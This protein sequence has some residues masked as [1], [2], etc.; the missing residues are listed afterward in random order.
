MEIENDFSK[1][2]I[3]KNIMNMAV[4]MILAQLVNVLY[5][6][7]DRI[8][9]GRMP[10]DAFLALTGVGICLPI[11]SMV[12]AFANLFGMGG[13]PLCSI[14]RGRQNCDEAEKIM[15]NSFLMLV[16]SG[17]I[18]T[19]IGLLI[20]KP[21]LYLFGAS[22]MTFLYA[23]QYVTIYLLGNIFVM[24]SLGMNP[25]INAQ[26]FGRIGM[27]TVILGAII[28]IILDPILIFKLDMGV[29][30][31]ALATIISQS[32]SAIWVLGF[33]TGKKAILKLKKSSLRLKKERIKRIIGLGTSGFVMQFTNSL[34]QIVCNTTLQ[35]YGGDLYVGIMT[36][37]NSIRE[38][39][40]MPVQGLTTGAQPVIGFNYGAREYKRVKSSIKFT[41]I[42]SITYTT[43]SW[44][45]LLGFPEFF[46]SIF[47]NDPEVIKAGIPMMRL[48]YATFFMMALQFTGQ[49]TFVALGK[50]KHAVF[51]STF[52]KVI[53]VTPLVI[54]LPGFL[55]LGTNG[56]F[57]AEP[58]SQF[59]GGT[60]CFTTML[61][62]IR[63]E[64]KRNIH[65]SIV[66]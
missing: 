48:F 61:F 49:T 51:F 38:F 36:I 41:A 43:L 53:L 52:R 27:M 34:V 16:S 11:I 39:I 28:N 3:T 22:E 9:I 56:I 37:L 50:A 40:T 45:L 29:Q 65:R 7:I 14:E 20:K 17:I 32:L 6:I 31:A 21:M 1:G 25:F 62:T 63:K 18:L 8:F 58:I 23:D 42:T 4:P 13:A 46:I 44:L 64:I 60:A 10:G 12:M 47:N 55:G 54:L 2:S 66:K 24:I 15:G 33:L 5:N 59:I 57:I 35:L 26:G 30:G 19:I